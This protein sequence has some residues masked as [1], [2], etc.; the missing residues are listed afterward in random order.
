VEL[1]LALIIDSFPMQ[2]TTFHLAKTG[3][4]WE[5]WCISLVRSCHPRE[6]SALSS[7]CF[8]S[9]Q[10]GPF[11]SVSRGENE[12]QLQQQCHFGRG[13]PGTNG[14]SYSEPRLP[15]GL[16]HTN[17]RCR[18]I[19]VDGVFD[20]Y[21]HPSIHPSI[22]PTSHT[23]TCSLSTKAE[24]S[25]PQYIAPMTGACMMRPPPQRKEHPQLLC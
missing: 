24:A 20:R 11:I 22:H 10:A 18:R 5:R 19:S 16:D 23:Y 8:G 21:T 2:G 4:S 9:H 17:G 25:N 15:P 12:L 6:C 3:K 7:R 13:A 1:T 14:R